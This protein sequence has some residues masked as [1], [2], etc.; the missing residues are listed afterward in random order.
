MFRRLLRSYNS[1]VLIC[2]VGLIIPLPLRPV[3]SAQKI[4][5]SRLTDAIESI[6]SRTATLSISKQDPQLAASAV[7]ESIN[8]SFGLGGDN[9]FTLI[10][11]S[12]PNTAI[13]NFHFQ[14]LFKNI[15]VWGERIVVSRSLSSNR[16]IRLGGTLINQIENDLTGTTPVIAAE[17]ALQR[18]KNA[19]RLPPGRGLARISENPAYSDESS[20][21][22]VFVRPSDHVAKLS[23]EVSFFADLD[24]EMGSPTRPVFLIDANTGETLYRYDSLTFASGTGPGGNPKTGE[25]RYG[26]GQK[27]PALD[28]TDAGSGGCKLSSAIVDTEDL[29]E[30]TKDVDSPYGFSCYENTAKLINGGFAPMNDAHHFGSVIFNMWKDWYGTS[31]ISQKLIMRVHYGNGYENAF[32]NGKAMYFGDGKTTFYPLVALDVTSHEIAHGYTEQHSKL[33]YDKQSGGINEAFSDMAGVAAEFYNNPAAQPDFSIGATIFKR[34]GVALRYM[35]DP[36]KDGQSISSAKNYFDG[37]DVHLSSGVY[38][39]AFCTLAQ[40]AGWDIRKAFQVFLTANRDYW[41][42]STDFQ[43]GA[44]SVRDAAKSLGYSTADVIKAFAAV[45]IIIP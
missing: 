10:R 7:A 4:E 40:T 45:D 20:H 24:P 21:L 19:V 36:A 9:Q 33:I 25:Y 14:Q 29:N 43:T 28:I 16:V 8:P 27:F 5:L 15:P 37:L 1:L 26:P 39:K 18:A 12:T 11:E 44:E 42:P 41:T 35:C 32:W 30:G 13:Q 2:M 6:A 38:N 23:Y 3:F 22:V 31:P 17:S 34:N